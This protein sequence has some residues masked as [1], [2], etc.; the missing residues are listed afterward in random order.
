MI[1]AYILDLLIQTHL[2]TQDTFLTME[3]L[4]TITEHVLNTMRKKELDRRL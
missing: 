1:Q 2:P 4:D 3:P